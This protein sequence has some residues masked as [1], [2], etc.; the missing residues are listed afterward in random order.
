LTI[1]WKRPQRL[2]AF[3]FV[4]ANDY[5]GRDPTQW[6]LHCSSDQSTWALS[7][8]QATD[9]STP[10][11]RRTATAWFAL[12]LNAKFAQ[13][14]FLAPR[15]VSSP[16]YYANNFNYSDAYQN[17]NYSDA[18]LDNYSDTEYCFTPTKLRSQESGIVEISE[19][20]FKNGDSILT[21]HESASAQTTGQSALEARGGFASNAIDGN[22]STDWVSMHPAALCIEPR[23]LIEMTSFRFKTGNRGAGRDPTQWTLVRRSNFDRFDNG[24]MA[25]QS[26]MLHTQ[27]TDQAVPLLRQSPTEWFDIDLAAVPF[28]DWQDVPTDDDDMQHTEDW[29]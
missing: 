29:N 26:T 9:Y 13:A 4:T 11:L 28:K 27:S 10:I 16:G 23:I 5:S 19:I 3:R 17:Y 12:D 24:S 21:W 7:H 14:D 1:T 18:S 22:S 15:H 25:F 8:Q 20:E 6:T 2:T